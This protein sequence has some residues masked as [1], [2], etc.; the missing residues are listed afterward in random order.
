MKFNATIEEIFNP[1]TSLEKRTL[2]HLFID[3]PNSP[4]CISF[5]LGE[6]SIQLN[7]PDNTLKRK[8]LRYFF[9]ALVIAGKMTKGG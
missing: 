6:D 4:P 2:V 1:E 5:F 3:K 8:N 9:R 7:I